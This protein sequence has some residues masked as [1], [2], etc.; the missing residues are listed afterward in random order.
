MCVWGACQVV[1]CP[2]DFSVSPIVCNPTIERVHIPVFRPSSLP[3]SA[4]PLHELDISEVA[5]ADADRQMRHIVDSLSPAAAAASPAGGAAGG[6]EK[7]ATLA[8]C[9]ALAQREN[10]AR[11]VLH[12]ATM[13]ALMRTLKATVHPSSVRLAAVT[14]MGLAVRNASYIHPTIIAEKVS[15]RSM[16]SVSW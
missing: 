10:T 6:G 5:D 3:F 1:F 8:Y 11:I 14:A 9:C 16:G 13:T 4:L 15:A 7:L 2:D 12:T